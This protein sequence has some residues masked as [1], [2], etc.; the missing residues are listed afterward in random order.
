MSNIIKGYKGIMDLDLT[1]VD[2][3]F[4][5][6]LVEQHM[7]DIEDYKKEQSK[8]KEESRYD[9]TIGNALKKM[10]YHNRMTA[11][12]FFNPHHYN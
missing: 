8:L 9:N 2:P 7:K 6:S 5:K 12:R 1:N 3:S 10:E 11:K 4:H